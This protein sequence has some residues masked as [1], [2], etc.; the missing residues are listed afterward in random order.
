M[1]AAESKWNFLPFKPGLVGGHCIGVDPYYLTFKAKTIGYSPK[2]ILAG[3][4]IND[5]MGIHIAKD[6]LKK[7]KNQNIKIKG[8]R[9]LIMGL[10]FKENCS[11]IRN[12]RSKKSFSRIKKVQM[13]NR[14]KRSLG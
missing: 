9:I 8:A 1:S 7:L 11:D 13:Q 6:L 14:F 10:T 4:E 12:S 5:N 3:R 2:I